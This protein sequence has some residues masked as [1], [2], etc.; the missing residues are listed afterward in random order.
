MYSADESGIIK[1]W[2]LARECDTL[3]CIGHMRSVRSIDYHPFGSEYIVSGSNDTTVRLWDIRINDCIKKYRG[4][5]ANVNSVKFSPDG[6]WIA[7]GGTEGSVIIWDIRMSKQLIEFPEHASPVTCVQFHPEEMLLGAGRNDG[8]VDLYDLEG[9]HLVVRNSNTVFAT[10]KCITF[11]EKGDCLYV[12]STSGVSAIGWEPDRDL[13]H[14]ESSWNMLGDMKIK[15]KQLLCG[16]YEQLNAAVYVAPLELILKPPTTGSPIVP[17]HPVRRSF[18][19]GTGKLRVSIGA[20]PQS[21]T[22]TLEEGLSS[23]NLSIEMI[24]EEE[25]QP[26]RKFEAKPR[27]ID[28]DELPQSMGNFYTGKVPL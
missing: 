24:E 19:R 16:A 25:E 26:L 23:P 6:S 3:T 10:V 22:Y 4:H 9:A 5:M 20:K 14:M 27:N 11:S 13:G 7:S 18:N 8:T 12:G 2:D 17:N 28:I 1:R 15:N 21:P